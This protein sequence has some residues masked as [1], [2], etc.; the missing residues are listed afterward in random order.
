MLNFIPINWDAKY[1]NV[2]SK[3]YVLEILNY[4]SL[5]R[6]KYKIINSKKV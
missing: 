6:N 3:T 1:T 5:A 2:N 4:N